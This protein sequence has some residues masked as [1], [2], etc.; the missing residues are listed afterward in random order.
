MGMRALCEFLLTE[1]VY[2]SHGFNKLHGIMRVRLHGGIV[3]FSEDTR[4]GESIY[5]LAP[6]VLKCLAVEIFKY[7]DLAL[8]H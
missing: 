3:Y 7:I 8:N 1:G 6:H 5:K 4:N 2:I